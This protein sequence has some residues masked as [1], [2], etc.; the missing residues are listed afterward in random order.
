MFQN[1]HTDFHINDGEDMAETNPE[2]PVLW[3]IHFMLPKLSAN[4][5]P[6]LHR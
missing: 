5:F 4:C 3:K 1:S 2:A 6:V